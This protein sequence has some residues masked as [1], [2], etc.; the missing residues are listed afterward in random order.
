MNRNRFLILITVAGFLILT[1]NFN[2]QAQKV[3]GNKI[4]NWEITYS[5]FISLREGGKSFSLDSKGNFEKRSKNNKT[6]ETL[7]DADLQEIVK[8]LA[9]LNLP[10]TKTKTVKGKGIYDY[11]Y[12]HFTIELD[13]RSYL[14][15]GLSFDDADYLVLSKKQ[16]RTFAK[17]KEKLKEIGAVR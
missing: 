8:L 16:Q 14:M 12:W 5:A 4:K 9:E 15:E 6:N 1:G 3:Q 10:G 11:P 13:G 7:K 2:A 17:L